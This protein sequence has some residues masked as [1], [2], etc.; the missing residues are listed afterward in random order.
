MHVTE[1]ADWRLWRL[2]PTSKTTFLDVADRCPLLRTEEASLWRALTPFAPRKE[3]TSQTK[4]GGGDPHCRPRENNR[5]RNIKSKATPS[6]RWHMAS[7]KWHELDNYVLQVFH[8]DTLQQQS[9]ASRNDRGV[10]IKAKIRFLGLDMG[11]IRFLILEMR[12]LVFANGP[13]R[14]LILEMRFLVLPTRLHKTWRTSRFSCRTSWDISVSKWACLPSDCSNCSVRW[15]TCSQV[16]TSDEHTVVKASVHAKERSMGH[17]VEMPARQCESMYT[18]WPYDPMTLWPYD[19][20]D[21][22]TLWPYDPMTL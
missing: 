18:L 19:P 2:L 9:E 16:N 11:K 14:F 1:R 20:I 5:N 6:Y 15:P 13:I 8:V 4:S 7:W 3:C 12:L 10:S 21:P 17:A 22:M